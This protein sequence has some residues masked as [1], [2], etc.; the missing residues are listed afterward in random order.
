MK[1]DRP[2]PPEMREFG[3]SR[4]IN[5]VGQRPVEVRK[6][7]CYWIDGT[8]INLEAGQCLWVLKTAYI[9]Y[10]GPAEEL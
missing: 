5:A 6:A 9:R 8:V 7:G 2:L 10:R 3:T 4:D 1:A